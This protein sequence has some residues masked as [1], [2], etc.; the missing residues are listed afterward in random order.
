MLVSGP[1]GSWPVWQ[2]RCWGT[3]W[4]ASAQRCRPAPS[5]G[6]GGRDGA[7]GALYCMKHWNIGDV[8]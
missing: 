3:P 5:C 1:S 7:Y 4:P 6:E 2:R 8:F